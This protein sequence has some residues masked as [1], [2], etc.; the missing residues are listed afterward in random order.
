M[1]SG[2]P[3]FVL[4]HARTGSTLIRYLLDSHAEVCCPPELALGRLCSDLRYTLALTMGTSEENFGESQDPSGVRLHAA[5]RSHV[6]RIMADYCAVRQ[7]SRWCD[8]STN[9]VEHLEALSEVFPDGQY[10]C[11]H[12]NALDVVHSLLELF[13]FGFAGRYAQMVARSPENV[14]DA[15][16]DTWT[17]ATRAILDFEAAHPTHCVRVRYEDFVATPQPVAE[18]MFS[19]LGLSGGSQALET[20]FAAN[21]QPG[22]G[23]FKI[24]FTRQIEQSRVGRGRGLPRSRISPDRLD[25]LNGLQARLDYPLTDRDA[26]LL[27]DVLTARNRTAKPVRPGNWG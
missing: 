24:Q 11:L 1:P 12:R 8:K 21:H 3:I 20:M 6:D 15:M 9:N 22:P 17:E 13:R 5:V 19:F 18:R 14:I 25:M 23:D 7:K 10:V 26:S 16:I 4:S 2:A 27:E